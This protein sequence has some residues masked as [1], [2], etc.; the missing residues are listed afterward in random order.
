M[1]NTITITIN[2][3]E[4]TASTD[5]IAKAL[6]FYL[7]NA[8]GAKDQQLVIPQTAIVRDLKIGE[9]F[10]YGGIKWVKLDHA[11]GG[12]LVLAVDKQAD[13]LIFD[14][15]RGNNWATSSLR[16]ELNATK[17]GRFTATFLK[18]INKENLIEFKRDLSA[19]DGGTEYG[20]CND[21]V[22]LYTCA[23]YRRYRK[24]IPEIRKWHWTITADTTFYPHIVR[25]VE[26]YGA[27]SNSRADNDNGS[28]RPLC[29]LRA[30]TIVKRVE[31]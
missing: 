23:E 3:E 24:L 7:T 8:P 14:E 9:T 6:A 21:F 30:N 16:K 15:T 18:D 20:T 31:S 27:L 29:V 22:S 28:V 4:I 1:N 5:I 19:D 10:L 2:G 11:Y 26:P 17:D 13:D 12:V 25:I